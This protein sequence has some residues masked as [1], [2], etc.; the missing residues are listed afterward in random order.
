MR[1][2]LLTNLTRVFSAAIVVLALTLVAGG[3]AQA[4]APVPQT[5]SLAFGGTTVNVDEPRTFSATYEHAGGVANLYQGYLIIAKG[6]GAPGCYVLYELPTDSVAVRNDLGGWTNAGKI[7]NTGTAESSWCGIDARAT[8]ATRTGTRVTVNFV[9]RMHPRMEGNLRA[10]LIAVDTDGKG[11]PWGNQTPL[12]IGRGPLPP[13]TVSARATDA[14]ASQH[15]TITTVYSDPNH[16]L[17]IAEAYLVVST[18]V[19]G[20]GCYVRYVATNGM[21]Q[22][23]G[24][25]DVWLD[26]GKP[27]SGDGAESAACKLDARA[28]KI[29]GEADRLTGDWALTFKP[30]FTGERRMYLIAVDDSDLRTYW[31]DRG[32]LT[33]AEAPLT[34][35]GRA[36]RF[37]RTELLTWGFVLFVLGVA[38]VAVRV[39]P[40]AAWGAAAGVLVLAGLLA[41]LNLGGAEAASALAFYLLLL[42]AVLEGRERFAPDFEVPLPLGWRLPQ[43]ISLNLPRRPSSHPKDDPPAS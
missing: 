36:A 6:E 3:R 18:G 27:G 1:D 11:S 38:A 2:R 22:L 25:N 17:S 41:T 5:V 33:I 12:T 34:A 40:R 4:Q 31:D 21:L 9:L 14:V 23:R 10:Y 35:G 37:V 19:G 13:V 26:A 39:S 29:S 24:D 32:N 15:T 7:G 8:Q 43:R 16:W 30:E 20:G 28:T 42:G